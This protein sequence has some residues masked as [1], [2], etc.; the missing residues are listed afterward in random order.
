VFQDIGY[1]GL[2]YRRSRPSND[3]T[4]QNALS[5]QRKI[6][7]I[8]QVIQPSVLQYESEKANI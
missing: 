6:V 3:D 1:L 8:A 2:G 4:V 7:P 5:N